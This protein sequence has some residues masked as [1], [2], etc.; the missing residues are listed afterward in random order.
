MQLIDLDASA[1]IDSKESCGHKLSSAYMPPE[2][3]HF[4]RS[5]IS[6]ATSDRSN[7][8]T[9]LTPHRAVIRNPGRVGVSTPDYENLE[10]QVSFDIW[11]LGCVM[12]YMCTGETLWQVTSDDNLVDEDLLHLLGEWNIELKLRKLSKIQ[13]P[14]ARNLVSQLLSKDPVLRPDCEHILRH[15]FIT[16]HVALGRMP[17]EVANFDVFISYRVA[18]D[19]AIAEG[20]YDGLVAAGARV[21]M[22]KRCLQAGELWELGFCKGLSGSRIFL[23]LLSRD[24]INNG[25]V[26][27][28]NFSKLVPSS[29]CDNVF[30]E[31][32]LALELKARGMIEHI[33]PVFIG[34]M[35]ADIVGSTYSEYLFRDDP[36][37]SIVAHH[38]SCPDVVVTSVEEKLLAHL[39]GLGLGL[40]L[41]TGC[42]A[43]VSSVVGSLVASQGV[44]IKGKD[45]DT[46][47]QAVRDVKKL[48]DNLPV[49]HIA[50]SV[51]T[52]PGWNSISYVPQ[53]NVI[54]ERDVAL[55]TL[56]SVLKEKEELE[57]ENK[58]LVELLRQLKGP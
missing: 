43:S 34:D 53:I 3:V 52:A 33:C 36:V 25:S 44:F 47:G 38:P 16:G 13:D 31:Q 50:T 14:V 45:V 39:D 28:Q 5:T 27:W 17:G 12:Y 2:M 29:P 48:V 55:S 54:I 19:L 11:S 8:P 4:E 6:A 41:H 15:G 22:D 26:E 46:I 56:A 9:L 51:V 10:A 7:L 1:K 21:W 20:I 30:L 40:P 18:S 32:R 23:P 42:R 58:K 49:E 35:S 37:K 57:M 24:G